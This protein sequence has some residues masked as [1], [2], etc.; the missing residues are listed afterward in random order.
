MNFKRYRDALIVLVALA[1]PFWF[2]RY[3][4]RRSRK[5]PTGP[6]KV[7]VQAITPIQNAVALLATGVSELWTDYVYLVDVHNKNA[8]LAAQNARLAAR[9]RKLENTEVE[10]RRLR[11]LLELKN[12]VNANMVSARVLSKDTVEFFRVSYVTLDRTSSEIQDAARLPVITLDGVVGTTGRVAGDTVEVQLVVDAG[13]GVDV[14]V[15]RTGARGFVR[16][17]GSE[18]RYECKVEYVQRTDEIDVGDLLVTSGWGKRFPPGIPVARVTKV[19]KRDFGIYQ[20]VVAEPT[21]DFS[22]LREV[23]IVLSHNTPAKP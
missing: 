14:V 10:N 2:L 4:L 3:S 23:L 12:H 8:A 6:D 20:T 7:I 21:V 16:G 15:E 22:R 17:T 5:P 1:V 18:T 13:S 19:L 11:G 9:I